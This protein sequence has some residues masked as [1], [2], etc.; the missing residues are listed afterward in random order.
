MN[1]KTDHKTPRILP[2]SPGDEE[3]RLDVFVAGATR[4]TRSRVQ[5]LIESGHILV[6]GL[7]E[8]RNYRL[9]A[10]D[11]I[12]LCE[13][14]E[15]MSTLIPE[16]IPLTILFRDDYLAV[17][18]KPAGMVVYPSM[19]HWEGTLLNALA[20]H[21]GK[22][23]SVG[24]PLRPGVVHRL[25]MDTSGVMV[26]ALE[27][28]TYYNLVE[29]FRERTITRRYHTLLYGDMK[30]D[31]G[32]ITLSIGRSVADRKKMST[33]TNS[34]KAAL[35]RWRALKRFGIATL[36]EAKL[37]TGRTHQIRVHFSA[38]GHPVLGDMTYGKKSSLD[39]KKKRI[40]FPRQMLHAEHLGFIHPITGSRMKFNS[41]LPGDMQKCLRELEEITSGD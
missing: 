30:E 29:Q 21:A 19:G 35:T 31:M 11:I 34:G 28:E 9:R 36:V 27:D 24:G 23:A 14:E 15:Q 7:Q 18:D 13:P 2:V 8:N 10:A 16:D 3:E 40:N 12:E 1:D 20:Y 26:I 32:E 6:N 22:L 38:L 33:R 39:F 5:K 41:P 4:I 17:V 25:D 37:G